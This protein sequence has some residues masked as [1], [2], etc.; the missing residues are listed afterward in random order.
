MARTTLEDDVLDEMGFEASTD[1]VADDD[2][3]DFSDAYKM[4]KGMSIPVPKGFGKLWDKK[5][6]DARKVYE[7]EHALWDTVFT[8][9]REVGIAENDGKGVINEYTYRMKN[10]TDENI[11]RT[12]I[13]TIMRTTYMRNPSL[14][15]TSSDSA[16]DNIT[17]VLQHTMDFLLNKKTAP[18]INMKPKA[19]RWIL[20]AQL[21]NHG[22]VRLDYQET[23]G[24]L[25]EAREAL[26]KLE[27]DFKNAKSQTEIKEI[28]ARIQL[29]YKKMP[30]LEAKGINL[31][32]V[33][34]HK[35]IIDPDCTTIDLSD[36]WWLAE[37]FDMNTKSMH[38]EFYDKNEEGEWIRLSDG[39]SVDAPVDSDR[40]GTEES[41]VSTIMGS[42][43]DERRRYKAKD[44]TECCLVYDKIMRRIYLFNCDDW[45]YPL[46]VYEDTM[47]LSR[48]FRHFLMAFTETVDSIIQ[49]GEA[50]FYVGQA[51]EINKINR[52]A[53]EIRDS[54]FGA[55]IYDKE[56]IDVED[57]KKLI[58]HLRNPKEVEAFG[59]KKGTD[60]KIKDVIEVFVPPAFDY[61]ALFNQQPL[62]QVI[63]RSSALS[64]V[65]RGEQ[66]KTN[67]TNDAVN[68]YDQAKQQATGM[69]I[70]SIE[71]SFE[72]LGWAIS[73]L[74]V[75]KYTKEDIQAMLGATWAEK[76]TPMTVEEFNRAY[77]MQV[78][79]GSIEKPN[80][81]FKKKEAIQ[82]AQSVGQF[83]QAVP[84]TAT[85][86]ILRM[87]QAAFSSFL[88]KKED[89]DSLEQE[90]AANLT[91]GVSTNGPQQQPG[92]Q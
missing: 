28:V 12:N 90:A 70:D 61:Q 32:N 19:R 84:A 75:S 56:G 89:W 8:M 57:V 52:K 30:L 29:L 86:V 9:Y 62:R 54:A 85:K 49:P 76:F 18:G 31:T 45:S 36:A 22:I 1:S 24:S 6:T 87:F 74:I 68:Y 59:I 14:E 44:T 34:P 67:T 58:K 81:E 16:S 40:E 17:D 66:F 80:T 39:K 72:S 21:T 13:R 7:T 4:A 88:V 60:K 55:L 23:T 5:V 41:I 37:F 91:K 79:S 83:A 69:L 65:D 53:K 38:E 27:E 33:L 73:E 11:V 20:H 43:S 25:E 77:R 15:F 3:N 51:N 26:T 35:V 78:A 64:D 48:F 50:S 47:K 63:D 71:D 92:Q 10:T 82:I 2:E 42:E 46:W